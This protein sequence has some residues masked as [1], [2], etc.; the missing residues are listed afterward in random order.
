MK[1]AII[2]ALIVGIA[3]FPAASHSNSV[4]TNYVALGSSYAAGLGLGDTINGSPDV[5]RRGSGSYP[6]L[7]AKQLGARLVDA[8]CSGSTAEQILSVGQEGI[9]P[10]INAVKSDTDLVTITV[11]G[12]DLGYAGDMMQ[13]AGLLGG[14]KGPLTS[15]ESRPYARL[16]ATIIS[17]L[18]EIRRR[19]PK[20]RIVVATYPDV[21]PE[22]GTCDKL[23]MNLHQAQ[24]F[25]AIAERL[26]ATTREAASAVEGTILVDM[27][28]LSK[29]HDACSSLPWT[30]GAYPE[31]GFPYHPTSLG[32][33]AVASEIKHRL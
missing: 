2:A 17:V 30:T 6:R 7:L 32:A 13:V 23:D 15:A 12:N 27:S 11:G 1:L 29:G 26:A 5:C 21:V 4:A 19:A 8:T 16:E 24:I 18:K 14:L 22:K 20:A 10:Q 3:T 31:T 25:R 28:K 33:Q 9:P